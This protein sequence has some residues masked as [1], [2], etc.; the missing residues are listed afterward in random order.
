M[1]GGVHTILATRVAALS[2]LFAVLQFGHGSFSI[3]SYC[4]LICAGL[5]CNPGS[6]SEAYCGL[7]VLQTV[8]TRSVR[9][10]F[11]FFICIVLIVSLSYLVCGRVLL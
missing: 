4:R 5:R 6:G 8:C 3:K 2:S 10:L 7:I 9:A 11:A 1:G